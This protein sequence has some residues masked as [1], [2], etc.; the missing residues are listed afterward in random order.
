MAQFH[1]PSLEEAQLA[2]WKAKN[3]V[4]QIIARADDATRR[5]FVF[6]EGP[7][8]ANGMP[9]IH[10]T[11]SR[12]LKDVQ[13]RFR[14]MQGYRI[15]RKAGWDTHGLPVE[16][17]AEKR[18]GFTKK[19]D[20]EAHGIAKF[21][22]VCREV[23]W[24]YLDAW[25]TVTERVAYWIDLKNPY[26][27][28]HNDYIESL[29]W[30]LKAISKREVAGKSLLFKG[31]RTTPHCPRCVT[32]LSSH[33]LAQGYKDAVDPSVFI[34]FPVVG[35]EKTF[36]LAWTT[37][38]WTLPANVALAVGANITYVEVRVGEETL[39]LAQE[40]L[41]ALEGEHSVVRE[42]SGSDLVG[43]AYAPLFMVADKELERARDK[44][45]QVYAADFVSTT[46]GTGIV[47]IAPAYG[48]DDAK[49][50]AAH[51]LPMLQSVDAGGMV[52]SEVPGKGQFFKKADRAIADDLQTRGLL[53]K[54]ATVTHTYPFCWRCG[55]PVI[56]MVKA[57]WFIGMS[58][59]RQELVETNQKINW[60][61]GHFRDGRFGEWLK[62]A[63]DWALSRERYWGTPLPVWECKD[64]GTHEVIGSLAELQERAPAKNRYLLMRHGEAEQNV[65][66]IVS[67]WPEKK[68]W[69]LTEKG[70]E[71]VRKSAQALKA[72]GIDL[73]VASDLTRAK[74]TAEMIAEEL[75]VPV[76]FD[77]RLR[78]LGLGAANGMTVDEFHALFASQSERFA[79]APEGGENLREVRS[80]MVRFVKELQAQHAGK[81]IL[82]VSH[83]DPL[84]ML[85]TGFRGLDDEAS[86]KVELLETGSTKEIAVERLPYDD[87]GHM[88]LHR[89][90]ID[91]VTV[92]CKSCAAPMRRIPD[93]ADVWFD[94]GAM[95]FAQWHYPFENAGRVGLPGQPSGTNS[96]ADYIAEGV[97]QTRGWFYTLLAVSVALGYK[98]PPFKSVV[99]NGFILDKQGK[100][101][102]KSKGNV[103]APLE[104]ADKFGVDAL[105]YFFFA[106]SQ[107]GDDKL[108]D[109]KALEEITKKVFLILWNVLS[110]WQMNAPSDVSE[111]SRSQRDGVER[112]I[113]T[114]TVAPAD[115]PQSAHK[116]DQWLVARTNALVAEITAKLGEYD[117]M[118]ACRA[119]GDFVNELSTWYVRRSR[120]RF[121]SEGAEKDAAMATLGWSLRMLSLV[122]A[123][124]TPFLADALYQAVGG[125]GDSVHLEKW[126]TAGAVDDE[127]LEK[128]DVVRKVASAGLEQRA[129][130]GVA[131][132][133]A[134]A[135]ATVRGAGE[136]SSWMGDILADELNVHEVRSETVG[137]FGVTLDT[138][139]TPELL[140]EGAARE[141]VRNINDLRKQL[142]MTIADRVVVAVEG[143]EFWAQ[144]L[145]E[146]GKALAEGTRADAVTNGSLADALGEA[147]LKSGEERAV[148]RIRK[149]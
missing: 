145:A 132:R 14:T 45:Y 3:V 113:G 21:N 144:V 90:F 49:L 120:D 72:E 103:V 127:L 59:L 13:L 139:L 34:K 46:D 84:W 70:R 81:T 75:G 123:P 86:L 110:F 27:T 40:R 131:I 12:S 56:Y 85:D 142:K 17:T 54:E 109:D 102:S 29:W 77:E 18:L 98:E 32:S 117:Y 23:V 104:V 19:Q 6:F 116:L 20:I 101:M 44:A 141:L 47:H 52:T 43:M 8:G 146:H 71:Q 5:P 100:K 112:S 149:V 2:R 119:L 134:L 9:G 60:T 111:A 148:V 92:S 38:P 36:L 10:H 89:P 11:L 41:A 42:L 138:V 126:P 65:A 114:G 137:E 31:T 82:L 67:G 135:S 16:L 118:S 147:E 64:C 140:R 53:Y 63:K 124:F 128:M 99:V 39:I 97:D 58:R 28:Y 50:G 51:G 1:L 93:V 80:R 136:I 61:P 69:Q 66:G 130:V 24:E 73:I 37:T 57:S 30:V 87:Q 78:E 95:P 88:D 133:Q 83:G 129:S 68:A 122:M 48:E 22:D 26:V 105:R 76:Q 91:D 62:D 108:Y 15:D 121:K 143:G 106:S 4:G 33:E 74:E 7:P 55:T 107:P 94:S 35:R 25:N 79:K 125:E 115:A 96:P